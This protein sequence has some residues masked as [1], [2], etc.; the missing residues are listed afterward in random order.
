MNLLTKKL[1][2]L[3][4]CA[5]DVYAFLLININQHK[6]TL[7]KAKQ[8]YSL[9]KRQIISFNKDISFL[10]TWQTPQE[11]FAFPW[12]RCIY[13]HQLSCL[14]MSKRNLMRM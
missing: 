11:I 6:P 7:I 3:Q 1:T 13:R 10:S 9:D 12:Q 5:N 4:T 2:Y 14:R 8:L